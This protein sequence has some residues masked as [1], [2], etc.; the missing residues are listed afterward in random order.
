MYFKSYRNIICDCHWEYCVQCDPPKKVQQRYG[1]LTSIGYNGH[2]IV[3]ITCVY[4]GTMNIRYMPNSELVKIGKI[5]GLNL[6]C[7]LLWNVNIFIKN[8]CWYLNHT[9]ESCTRNLE[10]CYWNVGINHQTLAIALGFTYALIYEIC[11]GLKWLH[12][13]HIF[14]IANDA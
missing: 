12:R 10:H 7:S 5:Y 6:L 8:R 2:N 14:V 1:R 9:S 3:N 11:T 4:F 13:F